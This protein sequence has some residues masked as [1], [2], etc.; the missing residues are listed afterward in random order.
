MHFLSKLN[1]SRTKVSSKGTYIINVNW[2]VN[3]GRRG[4]EPSLRT[5]G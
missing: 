1:L 2:Q 5:A 4:K 3:P